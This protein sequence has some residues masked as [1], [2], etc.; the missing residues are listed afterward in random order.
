MN[1]D[2]LWSGN[3]SALI[4]ILNIINFLVSTKMQIDQKYS[5]SFGDD[6]MEDEYQIKDD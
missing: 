5:E 2:E 3:F 4:K 1:L 6:Q